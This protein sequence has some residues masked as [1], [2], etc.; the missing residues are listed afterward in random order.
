[1]NGFSD[2]IILDKEWHSEKILILEM[3][4]ILNKKNSINKRQIWTVFTLS[5][6]NHGENIVI[7]LAASA[8]SKDPQVK[9]TEPM[10]SIKATNCSIQLS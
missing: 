8:T 10:V 5:N 4:E 1:M 7:G 6:A 2:P 3:I 9:T